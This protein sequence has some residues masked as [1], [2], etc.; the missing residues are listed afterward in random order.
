LIFSALFFSATGNGQF[1]NVSGLLGANIVNE[2]NIY[3]DGVSFFDFTGDGWDDLT[4]ADGA[5]DPHFLINNNGTFEAADFEIAN[6]PAEH[7]SMLLW[8]DYDNDGDNDL[9]IT[10]QHGPLQLWNNDGNLNFTNVAVAAGLDQTSYYYWGAAFCDVDHDGFLDL[11]VAKYYHPVFDPE[12]EFRSVLYHNNG[13]GTFTDATLTSGIDLPPR[14]TFQ[15]VFL[16]YNNDGWEDLFLVIDRIA[17]TNELYEN[18]GDGTFTNVTVA[19]GTNQAICSMTGTVDDF[20]NDTDTDIYVSNGPNGNLLLRNNGNETYTNVA[21]AMGVILNQ[22]TWG[23][24]WLDYDNNSW[25]D[26]FVC[27]TSPVLDPIGNQFFVNNAGTGFTQSNVLV[28]IDNDDSESYMCAM[29]D[30]NNDG[31]YDFVL[32]NDDPFPTKLYQNDGGENN[33]L[34]VDLEGVVANKN[35]IGSWIHCYAGGEHYVRYTH[36]GENF[37]GQNSGKEIFGLAD[38]SSVDSLVVDWNSGTHDVYLNVEVNQVLHLVEGASLALPFLVTYNGDLVLCPG[39]SLVLD[40]GDFENYLWSTG[41]TTKSITVFEGGQYSVS[42]ETIFGDVAQSFPVT[43]VMSTP[44]EPIVTITHVN[45]YGNLDGSIELDFGEEQMS[46]IQ[47]SNDADGFF[48]V[49]NLAAGSYSF[50]AHTAGGC[51]VSDNV[52]VTQ[53]DSLSVLITTQ[54]VMCFGEQNGH[55]EGFISGGVPVY[56]INWNGLN[57]ESIEAGDYTVLVTDY[58]LCQKEISFTINQPDLL[59]ATM[60]T[61]N[62]LCF[63][64]QNGWAEVE[65]VGGVP[66]YQLDW[67]GND[68]AQLYAGNYSVIVT[69][70]NQ[71]ESEIQFTIGE[72]DE[73]TGILSTTDQFVDGNDGT[74]GIDLTGG[75]EPYEILWSTNQEDV[76][77][78]EDLPT[79][80]YNVQVT[81]ANGCA[82]D[83]DFTIDYIEAITE[84]L[85]QEFSVFPNPADGYAEIAGWQAGCLIL[86]FDC[87]GNFVQQSPDKKL[88]TTSL[89]DGLYCITILNNNNCAMQKL[90][91]Q[92][93]GN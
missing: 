58:H 19:S 29:G 77:T 71:C 70:A 55:A 57:P 23:S 1:I 44:P 7:I 93:Q 61:G 40:A 33:W 68:P 37:V 59:T 32:N 39:D 5:S 36:C 45:C 56:E 21:A 34:S 48:S 22:T 38:F 12:P 86:V 78:I 8:A 17:F 52:E 80:F 49:F 20:D 3:G 4:I 72:P 50:N 53:P 91:I 30:F 82:F 6:L 90:V 27:L 66:G 14:T 24:M 63:G 41:D 11:Y 31:Y 47:W 15:P 79:G 2:G 42:A 74:A 88:N 16:D 65:P 60:I 67:S 18:N 75:S 92:H 51:L 25:Q 54:N 28:G 76:L 64:E 89:P 69:D 35:G 9:L 83:A 81:D 26:L 73:L 87:A 13:N 10:K 43:I 85:T 46:D 62:V 84:I